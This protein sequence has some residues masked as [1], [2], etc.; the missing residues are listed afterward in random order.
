MEYLAPGALYLS[1]FCV[2]SPLAAGQTVRARGVVSAPVKQMQFASAFSAD[3]TFPVVS[4]GYLVSFS[5]I[6]TPGSPSNVVLTS[7]TTGEDLRVSLSIPGASKYVLEDAALTPDLRL[8]AV[9]SYAKSADG[10]PQGIVATMDLTGK[11]ISTAQMGRFVASHI[12]AATDGTFWALGQEWE[13]ELQPAGSSYPLLRNYTSEGSLKRSYFP[14]NELL[15]PRLDL[16]P[17]G[18]VF[19][20]NVTD[21]YLACGITSVGVFV[22]LLDSWHWFE[23]QTQTGAAKHWTMKPVRDYRMTGLALVSER[24]AYASFVNG[25]GTGAKRGLYHLDASNDEKITWVRMAIRKA[26]NSDQVEYPAVTLLGRQA[27][28][29]LVYL[30]GPAR[31]LAG[32]RVLFWSSTP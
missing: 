11:V 23:V 12:C 30:V 7:L 4:N 13:R 6:I 15:D 14:S 18:T 17:R 3:R 31:P 1:F 9:G 27:P 32:K 5:R 25:T 29:N 10:A 19:G 28:N 22:G 16:R 8:L 21:A 26:A 20:P 24:N 2:F